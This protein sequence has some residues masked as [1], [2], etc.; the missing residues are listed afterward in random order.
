MCGITGYLSLAAGLVVPD[1]LPDSVASLKH[2]GPDEAGIWEGDSGVGLGHARLSILDL[3]THASQPMQSRDGRDVIVFN[4]EI[5]NY[6]DIRAE[7]LGLGHPFAGSGDTE[8]VLAALRQ[9]GLAAV[10]RFIGMFAIA[11]WNRDRQELILIRDRLGV[12]PLYYAWDGR[13]FWFGSELKARAPFRASRSELDPVAI[14]DFLQFGYIGAPRSIYRN[15]SKLLPGHW[16]KIDRSGR[17]AQGAYWRIPDPTGDTGRYD[18]DASAD[19]LEAL[20][21]DAFRLR[22]VSDVPVG[23]FLS[24]GVDSSLVA[25]VLARNTPDLHTF[26][27]GFREPAYDESPYAADV[28]AH[29][30]TRHLSERISEADA[31]AVLPDWGRL[32]DEPFGDATGIPNLLVSRLARRHVKVVLSADGGDELFG[33]YAAY[34]GAMLRWH[35]LQRIPVPLGRMMAGAGRVAQ[36]GLPHILPAMRGQ[37]RDRFWWKCRHV[38]PMA[39]NATLGRV[40]EGVVSHWLPGEIDK[41]TGST[42][43]RPRPDADAYPGDDFE[44]MALW[45]MHHYL[46]DDILT[47]VDRCTMA[48]SIEGREPLLDHRIVEFAASLPVSAKRGA[49]GTKHLLRRILYRHVPRQLVDRPKQG[50]SVPMA[51]WLRGDLGHLLDDYL[52]AARLR[53]QG[54]FDHREVGALVRR[55]RAGMQSETQR[56]WLLLAFQMWHERWH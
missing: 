56:V 26:T 10:S 22:M 52:D 27:M 44:R 13:F 5:Y 37:W 2:R 24:G 51:Q 48:E 50:F 6:R 47:K 23:V 40:Y 54:L 19:R 30:G 11:W 34:T 16:L 12:K 45:D 1:E 20:L 38:L 9:W 8:V 35:A 32:F 33:G 15:V 29:L 4:G 39:G 36:T 21:D 14:R 46:P 3:S 43:L 17:L 53:E 28:A 42:S 25:A 31:L 18:E 55:F 49:L 41:L 7:L